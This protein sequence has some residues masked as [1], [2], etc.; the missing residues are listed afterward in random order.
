MNLLTHRGLYGRNY[1]EGSASSSERTRRTLVDYPRFG[2]ELW[3]S[4]LVNV[5]P[6]ERQVD[7]SGIV[8]HTGIHPTIAER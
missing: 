5:G 6:N 1:F 3:T 7:N 2:D 4:L 8:C